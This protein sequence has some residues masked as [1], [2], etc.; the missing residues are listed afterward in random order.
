MKNKL[1]QNLNTYR[2]VLDLTIEDSEGTETP[3]GKCITTFE[4]HRRRDVTNLDNVIGYTVLMNQRLIIQPD[5]TYTCGPTNENGYSNYPA[6]LQNDLTLKLSDDAPQVILDDIFP[7]TINTA[8]NTSSNN[9][10]NDTDSNTNESTSGSSFT[11]VNSFSVGGNVGYMGGP[12]GGIS[13]EH[14]HSFEESK[15]H[16]QSK[17][18][19]HSEDTNKTNAASMS[20][21]DW[22]AYSYLNE[23]SIAPTWVWG[24]SYPWDVIQYNYSLDEPY[25]VLP[26]FVKQR[27]LVNGQVMPPSELSLFGLDFSMQAS[28]TIDYNDGITTD[29]TV[30]ISNLI[31]YFTASHESEDKKILKARLESTADARQSSFDSDV[32]DLSLYALNPIHPHQGGT[33]GAYIGFEANPFTYAPSTESSTFKIV[34]PANNLQV[35]GKGFDA[36]ITTD[37]TS[38]TSITINFKVV[39]VTIDYSLVFMHWIGEDSGAVNLNWMVNDQWNGTLMVDDQKGEG[40]ENNLSHLNLRNTDFTSLNFHDYLQLGLNEVVINFSAVDK[41]ADVDYTLFAIGLDVPD[42][43]S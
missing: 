13:A 39:D 17:S 37:L 28:W 22:S 2:E 33:T 42:S 35:K 32:L 18:S 26:D 7:R 5:N 36:S 23:N 25:I 21:K 41:E 4:I 6:I 8:V 15:S 16:S 38:D 40:A 31:Q 27:M 14:S 34:S 30:T 29:E 43:A 19:T 3:Y 10:Q 24:Q 9:S 1:L 12:T 11:N 20:V